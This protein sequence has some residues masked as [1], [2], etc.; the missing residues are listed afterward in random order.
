[1]WYYN[2]YKTLLTIYSYVYVDLCNRISTLNIGM[3][4]YLC[5]S[6]LPEIFSALIAAKEDSYWAPFHVPD[7]LQ[8]LNVQDLIQEWRNKDAEMLFI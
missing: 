3:D 1:M 5:N 6:C 2:I 7:E 4:K 8:H